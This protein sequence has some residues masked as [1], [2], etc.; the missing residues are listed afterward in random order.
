MDLITSAGLG[1]LCAA[2]K[3]TAGHGDRWFWRAPPDVIRVVRNGDWTVHGHVSERRRSLPRPM[4][5]RMPPRRY[6]ALVLINSMGKMP[7]PL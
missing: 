1:L 7:L 2:L 5:R 3:E 6:N 4:A